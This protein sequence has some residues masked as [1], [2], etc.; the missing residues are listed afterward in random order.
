MAKGKKFTTNVGSF[1]AQMTHSSMK[2]GEGKN[3]N[4]K[5]LFLSPKHRETKMLIQL[6]HN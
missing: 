1:T 6:L 5:F 2:S 4:E 3:V